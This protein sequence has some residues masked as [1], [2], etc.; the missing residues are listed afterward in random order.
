MKIMTKTIDRSLAAPCGLASA[1]GS[2][3][4]HGFTLIELMVTMGIMALLSAMIA[5][6]VGNAQDAAKVAHT[7]A[8]IARLH[9][10]LMDRYE[11]Y[12]WRRLPIAITVQSGT[13]GVTTANKT[14]CDAIRELMRLELPDRWTDI[15]VPPATAV[16]RTS[17]S[18]SYQAAL[19]RAGSNPNSTY[20][21]AD[22]LY[23]IVTMGLEENDILE[24]FS[25]GD[26]GTDPNNPSLPCFIDSWGNPIQFLRWAPGFTSPLQPANPTDRDQT[27]PTGVYGSPTSNPPTFAL[28]PLIYSAGPDGFYDILADNNSFSYASQTPLN[29]PFGSGGPGVGFGSALTSSTTPQGSGQNGNID[30]IHNQLIGVH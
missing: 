7:R 4:R 26:I 8:V 15:T 22:C 13:G 5:V 10:L 14:R 28:Y 23:M 27:D 11:S 24:N 12:R 18:V 20:Q 30:N 9:T 1:A 16:S 21:G 6:A 2:G 19:A 29:N 3:R 17:A 25:Q